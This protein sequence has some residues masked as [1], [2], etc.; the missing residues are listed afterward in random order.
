M[1]AGLTIGAGALLLVSAAAPAAPK[2]A[3]PAAEAGGQKCIQ[4]EFV[5]NVRGV[6]DSSYVQFR[7]RCPARVSFFW[8]MDQVFAAGLYPPCDP[9]RG[10]FN[11]T[12]AQPGWTNRVS[13]RTGARIVV[14][15]RECPDG[16]T[17][18]SRID[19]RFSCRR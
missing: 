7:N 14:A 1:K 18:H 13:A 5:R 19:G 2:P 4:W 9:R 3:P 15:I 8:C 12:T 11:Q 10:A 17:A 6:F 16:Y